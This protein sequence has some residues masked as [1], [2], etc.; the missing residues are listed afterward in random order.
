MKHKLS[1]SIILFSFLLLIILSWHYLPFL[2]KVEPQGDYYYQ[3]L[4]HVDSNYDQVFDDI[5]STQIRAAKRF[6]INPTDERGINK[7]SKDSLLVKVKDCNLYYLQDVSYPYLTPKAA[8]ALAQIGTMYQKNV[9]K[10]ER[11]RLT[12]CMRTKE[13]IKNL[14]TKNN[15]AIDNSCHLYGTTFD[16]SY[17]KMKDKEKQALAC[18]LQSLRKAGYIYVKYEIQQPCFHITVRQ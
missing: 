10:H 16:I 14:K 17:A 15:N 13:H 5:Q 4:T 3:D 18:T 1:Y 2:R 12:S 7:A 9:G 6:G 8:D 11:I